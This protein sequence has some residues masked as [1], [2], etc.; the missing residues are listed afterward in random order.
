MEGLKRRRWFSVDSKS[1]MIEEVGVGSKTKV[2][3][4]ERR[5]GRT[6]W[7]RFGEEGAR[8]FLKSVVSLRTEADKNFEGLGWCENDR[9]YR[10][11]MRKN[12]FGR[13]LLCSVTDLDGKRHRL[14]FPEGNGLINGWTMLE[15]ALQDMGYKEGRGDRNKLTKIS[16]IDKLENQKEKLHPGTS[17]DIKNPGRSRQESIWLDISD[18]RQ[19]GELGVLKYG[20][21]GSWKARPGTDQSLLE[22]EAWAKRVWKLKGHIAIYPLNHNLFFMGFELLE[23]ARWVMENGSRICRGGV[24]KLEWWTPYSGCNGLRDQE[25]EVWIRVVGLPLHLWTG[26]ILEKIGDNCGGFIALDESTASKTDLLWAR[27]LVKMNSNLKPASVNLLAG[28]RSYELQI[29]WEIRPSV[30]EVYPRSS[31]SSGEPTD[32]REEDDRDTRA[33]GRVKSGWTIKRHN[34]KDGQ[35]KEGIRTTWECGAAESRL[36][37]SQPRGRSSK[38]GNNKCFEIQNAVG[39]SGRKG[40]PKHYLVLD[41]AK[42]KHGPQSKEKYGPHLERDAAHDSDQTQG[43][44]EGPSH[45]N[46]GEQC[47]RTTE[48]YYPTKGRADCKGRI[49]GKFGLANPRCS[50]ANEREVL[51]VEEKGSQETILTQGKGRRDEG[52]EGRNPGES[53][54]VS[55]SGKFLEQIPKVAELG[56][57]GEEDGS[58]PA[59]IVSL[60]N[61]I[62][63]HSLVDEK[64]KCSPK[65]SRLKIACLMIED[66]GEDDLRAERSVIS[67]GKGLGNIDGTRAVSSGRDHRHHLDSQAEKLFGPGQILS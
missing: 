39:I 59:A 40:K 9:R 64:S 12:C 65:D 30:A 54:M 38:V 6:S 1:F 13:F 46:I 43:A 31:R 41:S 47:A 21:V 62:W 42:E 8:T 17:L 33:N 36:T 20:V 26:K 23:E 60:G 50:G 15:G 55:P 61:V 49:G 27:I 29:W 58:Y 4:T 48:R 53:E 24:L 7:I 18:C 16:S 22:V 2:V 66:E 44:S 32:P 51:V 3:I 28:A 10:L 34:D 63:D 25:N 19:K 52:D 57:D 11:E 14:L 67:A 37:I 35:N 5:W 45:T 56:H